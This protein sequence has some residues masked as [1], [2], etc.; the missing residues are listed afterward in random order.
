MIPN[1]RRYY[2]HRRLKPVAMVKPKQHIVELAADV[3]PTLTEK[4][5]FYLDELR[6]GGYSIQLVIPN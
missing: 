4:M 2:L 1:T 3:E 6:G 5:R